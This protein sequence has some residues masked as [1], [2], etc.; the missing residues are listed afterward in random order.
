[1]K[2]IDLKHTNQIG[3]WQGKSDQ[4]VNAARQKVAYLRTIRARNTGA[5]E[6]A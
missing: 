2:A 3:D 6:G 5:L 4:I 1:V